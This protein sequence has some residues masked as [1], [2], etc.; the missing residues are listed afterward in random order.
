MKLILFLVFAIVVLLPRCSFY[1]TS[2][3]PCTS[4][5]VIV[6]LH[7]DYLSFKCNLLMLCG[8]IELNSGPKNNTAEKRSICNWNLNSITAHNFAKLV[9]FKAYNSIR[10]FNII[11]F[12]E[13]YL[14][15]NTTFFI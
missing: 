12:L 9:F 1:I 6:A 3:N 11:C 8:D 7:S 14:D 2:G 5:L 15:S 4:M 10:K 13:T